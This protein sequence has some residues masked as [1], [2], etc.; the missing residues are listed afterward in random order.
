MVSQH[1]I[2]SKDAK[3]AAVA[4]WPP[5]AANNSSVILTAGFSQPMCDVDYFMSKLARTLCQHG[6]FVLQVDP[7]GHG[8]S[9]GNLEDVTLQSL[10]QDLE[11]AIRYTI[12]KS[13]I[14]KL[15]C[16][17]RGISATIFSVLSHIPEICGVIG[18]N[19]FCIS[20]SECELLWDELMLAKVE[21]T[22]IFT[23]SDYIEYSDFDRQKIK[24]CDW[25]GALVYNL[26]GQ[27]LSTDIL[28]DLRNYN[29]P[30]ILNKCQK[31][32]LWIIY[33][34]K[35]KCSV[36]TW[37]FSK[38]ITPLSVE[39]NDL[40]IL[41]RDPLWQHNAIMKICNWINGVR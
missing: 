9:S 20:P 17:G 34:K 28:L 16:V 23:G 3:L 21:A 13:G 15:Y 10:Y 4:Y 5:D 8:D 38:D 25:L 40:G 37:D 33:D 36:K 19:P 24:F 32:S 31:D 39:H 27:I 14:D 2:C 1:F 11:Q 29:S 22:N 18:I 35:D 30:E 6:F 12:L 7:R 26:H 41:P